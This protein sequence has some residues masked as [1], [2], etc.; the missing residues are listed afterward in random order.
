M[1]HQSSRNECTDE[2]F[3]MISV[4]GEHY[5]ANSGDILITDAELLI[6]VTIDPSLTK[7][8]L[9]NKETATSRK[10]HACYSREYLNTCRK[11]YRKACHRAYM[12][13]RSMDAR[14]YSPRARTIKEPLAGRKG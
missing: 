3:S 9:N 5:L 14:K 10:P 8:E 12:F 2:F 7:I 4:N 11:S 1:K 6:E 13:R